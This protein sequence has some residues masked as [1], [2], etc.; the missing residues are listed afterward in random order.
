MPSDYGAIRRAHER[1]YGDEVGRYGQQLLVDRYDERTHFIYELLQN[2]ED[3]LARRPADH[4]HRTVRFELKSEHLLF[5][6]YGH[7]FTDSDV[8]AICSIGKSTK[9]RLTRIGR[10]G[11]GF[12][13]VFD[14]SNRPAV[15]S[16]DEHFRIHNFVHP[17]DV[18]SMEREREET[19]FDLPL[20]TLDDRAE[21]ERTLSSL[22]PS[23]LLF[24]R[25][26]DSIRWSAPKRATTTY[27]RQT[28]SIHDA[29]DF[30]VRRV[31]V[32]RRHG[33]RS[34]TG[35]TWTVFSRPIFHD[36]VAAG[37][38]EIAFSMADDQV[39]PV[40]RSPLIVFFPT[41]L[42]TD[43]GF[44]VQGPYRTTPNRD[45]VPRADP[46]NVHCVDETGALLVD[47]LIWM[48][49]EKLLTVDVLGT[50]PLLDAR[51][52]DDSMFAPL[53]STTKDA[54]TR[55]R[56]LPLHGGGFG[57]GAD[58]RIARS[59]RLRQLFRPT[60]LTALLKSDSRVSWVSGAV[61]ESRT[62]ELRRYLIDHLKVV[63]MGPEDV[64]PLLDRS[65]LEKMT[66]KW[67]RGL[68]EF[69]NDLPWLRRR[70]ATLPIV[71]LSNGEQVSVQSNE[72]H[73]AYLPGAATTDFPTVHPE[74]CSTDASMEFLTSLGLRAPDPI[75]DVLHNILPRYGEDVDKIDDS[76]YES[77]IAR[78]V[79]AYDCDSRDAR[80][81]LLTAL[82]G[83]YFIAARNAGTGEE[84]FCMAESVHMRSRRLV[85]LFKGVDDI[86]FVSKQ[87][88]ALRGQKAN[89]LLEACGVRPHL[90][91][92][93]TSCDLSDAGLATIRRKAG[94]DVGWGER[95]TD[96]TILGLDDL[97]QHLTELSLEERKARSRLLWESLT[98]FERHE[99][100]AFDIIYSWSYSHTRK[101]E[102]IDAEFIRTLNR[103]R[104][105]PDESGR[106]CVPRDVAFESLGWKANPFLQS[107]I[108]F[109]QPIIDRLATEAGFEPGVLQLLSDL[110]IETE[111]ELRALLGVSGM[112][113]GGDGDVDGDGDGNTADAGRAESPAERREASPIGGPLADRDSGIHRELSGAS[114]GEKAA[115]H[116]T[117][118]GTASGHPGAGQRGSFVSYVAVDPDDTVTKG[119]EIGDSDRSARLRVEAKA[120]EIILQVEPAWHRTPPGNRGFD[121]FQTADGAPTSEQVR[122]CEVKALSGSFDERGVGLSRAQFEFARRHGD[123][124]WL[125]V[126]EQVGEDDARILRIQDPAGKARTF[127]FD[128]GWR[129]VAE[130]APSE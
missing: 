95:P 105:V 65:F 111:A 5:R 6:H 34:A 15:H 52:D 108:L 85:S 46:W 107:R 62:P 118:S 36:G 122:W 78:I 124:Y 38:L 14:F 79:D 11:I 44:L 29:D 1:A 128:R 10:F 67:I 87:Y 75:D 68:Y 59:A 119:D 104:W 30:Q 21:I 12:K 18:P 25:H 53:F 112:D 102:K 28:R 42:E 126:V 49:D 8:R 116:Q 37:Y 91:T 106:L 125:Y 123:A 127:T 3:A 58:V 27:L 130:T 64:L 9:E 121:L 43:L 73:A 86:Y 77:D 22:D 92:Q 110:G 19:V 35:N 88:A 23:V 113:D 51:F 90:M 101:S 50:L 97:L 48:R 84:C 54:L 7:P 76:H 13:S 69:L 39:T 99:R 81:R 20:R 4:T 70:L 120:I 31:T 117:P 45:N 24:L 33:R 74:A 109:K 82:S 80:D 96:R 56:L 60:H 115:A 129:Q 93:N 40:R 83:A 114:N 72:E 100:D 89:R 55:E 94:F 2:A 98:D 66:N 61:S 16:G 103:S 41:V 32:T 63:E 57:R 26:I 71:R 17:Y 47:T